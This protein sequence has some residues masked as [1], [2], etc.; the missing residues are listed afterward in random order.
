MLGGVE[1]TI[2][3][4]CWL[5]VTPHMTLTLQRDYCAYASTIVYSTGV[6]ERRY[7]VYFK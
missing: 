4:S 3:G 6:I 2:T 5:L 1:A 7:F